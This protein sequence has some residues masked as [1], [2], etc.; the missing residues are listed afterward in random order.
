MCSQLVDSHGVPEFDN[1]YLDM[2]GVIHTCARAIASSGNPWTEAE[3]FLSMFAYVQALFEKIR[4]KKVLFLAVDGKRGEAL[5]PVGAL[6]TIPSSSR[7][8]PQSQG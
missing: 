1:F 8:R 6:I 3:M 5:S 2:N 4:P 7:R